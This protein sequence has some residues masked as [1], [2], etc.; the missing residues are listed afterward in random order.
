MVGCCSCFGRAPTVENPQ[1][2]RDTPVMTPVVLDNDKL[3]A[4]GRELHQQLSEQIPTIV[5]Q[6][7]ILFINL[8][9]VDELHEAARYNPC[10]ADSATQGPSST[11]L[12]PPVTS[13]CKEDQDT[14]HHKIMQQS[15]SDAHIDFAPTATRITS[16][17]AISAS[18]DCN[19]FATAE[20]TPE[21]AASSLR[22]HMPSTIKQEGVPFLPHHIPSLPSSTATIQPQ[23][24]QHTTLGSLGETKDRC[25]LPATTFLD[26]HYQHVHLKRASPFQTAS[27]VASAAA[28]ED[29]DADR[30]NE[31]HYNVT[32]S[33]HQPLDHQGFS[34]QADFGLVAGGHNHEHIKL[35]LSVPH[36]GSHQPNAAVLSGMPSSS[37][38]SSSQVVSRGFTRVQSIRIGN[39]GGVTA[40]SDEAA[41]AATT[42]SSAATP[43][44]NTAVT[45]LSSQTTSP[46]PQNR[47]LDWTQSRHNLEDLIVKEQT[48][49]KHIAGQPTIPEDS[50]DSK[51]SLMMRAERSIDQSSSRLDAGT[52][53]VDQDNQEGR[54][55]ERLDRLNLDMVI[56]TGDGNCQ[57]R[58]LS[59]ELFGTQEYH[60]LVRKQVIQHIED[61]SDE[62]IPFLGE[63]FDAYVKAMSSSGT[64]GDELTL[65]AACDSYGAIV[66]CVTSEEQNWYISYEPLH[67]R[68]DRELFLAYIS[69]VHYNALRRRT[70][71][72]RHTTSQKLL[73][74]MNFNENGISSNTA[75]NHVKN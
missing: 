40:P 74:A 23:Q 48:R 72:T 42:T 59:N 6:R 37:V 1:F 62:F 44:T 39:S 24:S 38:L 31:Q 50:N 58:A 26:Q 65:R 70:S 61:K 69:P 14:A 22:D 30:M 9:C 10:L 67:R 36:S 68:L 4:Q 18:S 71:M 2:T 28:A 19:G 29:E 53:P 41:A 51:I 75:D 55:R 56:M 7:D 49:G 32:S 35:G 16:M 47:V 60:A 13:V 12:A 27:M 54:L 20:L 8:A 63:D 57:F 46:K 52:L 43:A 15:S 21:I 45:L 73:L 11:G 33:G 64:W 25:L 17:I 5:A 34:S 3:Q 66:R